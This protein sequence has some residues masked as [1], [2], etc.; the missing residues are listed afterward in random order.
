MP[1]GRGG[2]CI[3][4]K[5]HHCTYQHSYK[6][7]LHQGDGRGV[8]GGRIVCVCQVGVGGVEGVVVVL[9]VSIII[10]PNNSIIWLSSR[11]ERRV[12][13]GRLVMC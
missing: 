5:Q 6:N 9:S 7:E 3:V 11:D 2:N 10:A 12:M 8:I 4:G 1:L 13:S